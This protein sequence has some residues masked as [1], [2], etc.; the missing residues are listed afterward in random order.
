MM[1]S[2]PRE[3]NSSRVSTSLPA[4]ARSRTIA[5]SGAQLDLVARLEL[6]GQVGRD[7]A[8]ADAH[9]RELEPAAV[10][11]RCDRVA[12]LCLVAVAGGQP[13][14]NVLPGAMPSPAGDIESDRL[15][16]R[17]LRSH[18]DAVRDLPVQSPQYR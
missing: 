16:L 4:A 14:V 18:A 8:V 6:I 5:I 10:W 13:D 3:D 1:S 12:A 17:R 15:D 9:H 2:Q 11:R 7:L